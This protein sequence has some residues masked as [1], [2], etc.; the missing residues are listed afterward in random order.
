MP[1]LFSRTSFTSH[2]RPPSSATPP[3]A[4][5]P[6]PSPCPALSPWQPPPVPTC[7]ARPRKTGTCKLKNRLLG[8]DGLEPKWH[9][10]PTSTQNTSIPCLSKVLLIKKDTAASHFIDKSE[11]RAD[12]LR[13]RDPALRIVLIRCILGGLR[14]YLHWVPTARP[15]CLD[16]WGKR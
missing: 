14:F 5:P 4:A 15:A 8:G 1:L 16:I 13:T 9:S 11:L 2:C 12:F 6:S 3:P 10:M 7:H